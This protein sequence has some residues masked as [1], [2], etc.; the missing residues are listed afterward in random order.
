MNN[1]VK[2]KDLGVIVDSKLSFDKHISAKVKKANSLVGLIRRSFV[3]LDKVMFK[4]L[5]TSLVR[6]HLEY[7]AAV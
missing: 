7:E 2:K 3:Y 1:L 5:F 4:Q 6:P